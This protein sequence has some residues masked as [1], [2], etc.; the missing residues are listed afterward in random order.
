MERIHC[1][2]LPRSASERLYFSHAFTSTFESLSDNF[3]VSPLSA[4][5][6]Q[7]AGC[8]IGI[9][10]IR[11]IGLWIGRALGDI[12]KH[13]G[14]AGSVVVMACLSGAAMWW[15]GWLQPHEF[16]D[17]ATQRRFPASWFE[18]PPTF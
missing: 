12:V 7:P 8:S 11:S 4:K 10:S 17:Y 6:Q 2:T 13:A 9:V 3:F 18:H 15:A 1:F 14:L 16:W 5:R